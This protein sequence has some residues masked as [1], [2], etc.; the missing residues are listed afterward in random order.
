MAGNRSIAWSTFL[1]L[2]GLRLLPRKERLRYL[3]EENRKF[4]KIYEKLKDKL[5]REP[6]W[7][8]LGAVTKIKSPPSLA[9]HL[10]RLRYAGLVPDVNDEYRKS[11]SIPDDLSWSDSF[12]RLLDLMVSYAD[13]YPEDERNDSVRNLVRRLGIPPKTPFPEAPAW[14]GK[15]YSDTYR[16]EASVELRKPGAYFMHKG[17]V[18]RKSG[19]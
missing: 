9:N 2:N 6:T 18:G 13:E 5:K 3:T 17:A 7:G 8:E 10:F 12:A 15:L 19:G 16:D 4:Y 11:L 1:Y 14:Y